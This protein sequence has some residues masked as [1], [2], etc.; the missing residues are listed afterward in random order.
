MANYP[1][2]TLVVPVNA[3][4]F[5]HMQ[6]AYRTLLVSTLKSGNMQDLTT[7]TLASGHRC[8]ITLEK[9]YLNDPSMSDLVDGEFK[10]VGKVIRVIEADEG[11]ISLNRK[12][13]LGRLPESTLNGLKLIFKQTHFQNY[14]LPEFEWE[15]PGPVIQ[16]LPIAIFA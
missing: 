15:I 16:V 9:Q 5:S 13:A 8:V 1:Y 4:A 6:N 11:A 7:T 10:V 14:A 2:S 3:L 12:T